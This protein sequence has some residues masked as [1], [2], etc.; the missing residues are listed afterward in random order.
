MSQYECV[1]GSKD[2]LK[3]DVPS[4]VAVGEEWRFP[5]Q[6]NSQRAD[7]YIHLP[8]G[9]LHFVRVG[10][11]LP[12][13]PL[14]QAYLDAQ[15]ALATMLSRLEGHLESMHAARPGFSQM[16]FGKWEIRRRD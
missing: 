9:R 14:S 1:G 8:D 15:Q 7:V 16:P 5:Q 3:I 13:K 11:A 6:L 12:T 10:E 4:P 2:G